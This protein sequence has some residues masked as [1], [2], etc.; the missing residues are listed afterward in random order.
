MLSCVTCCKEP[1]LAVGLGS[2]IPRGSFLCPLFCDSA[3]TNPHSYASSPLQHPSP[4]SPSFHS[5]PKPSCS[6][7]LSPFHQ[8]TP[9]LSSSLEFISCSKSSITISQISHKQWRTH[10]ESL[11]W[12][13]LL[14]DMCCCKKRDQ[15]CREMKFLCTT[16]VTPRM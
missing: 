4:S 13:V 6:F 2:V 1:A 5:N 12:H 10:E 14:Q 15:A 11:A 7:S 16:S 3:I 8:S 9:P